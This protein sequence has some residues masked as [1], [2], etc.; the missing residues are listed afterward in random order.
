LGH[1]QEDLLETRLLR[2]IRGTGPQGLQAMKVVKE[3]VIRPF[4]TTSEKE[5]ARA[6]EGL[7]WVEDPSNTK[8]DYLRN[9]VRQ[10]WLSALE[11]KSPGAKKALARSL[12]LLLESHEIKDIGGGL[13]PGQVSKRMT[14]R[15]I[16]KAEFLGLSEEEKRRLLARYLLQLKVRHFTQNHL[17]E[18]LKHLDNSQNVHKFTLAKLDWTLTKDRIF[19]A[20]RESGKK[21][22]NILDG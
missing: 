13:A 14:R 20:R 3:G 2:L 12:E 17:R 11:E 9:W 8:A 16:L 1:H 4:L 5:I 18:I 10:K 15:G 7:V 22:K 21:A 6:S 19:A